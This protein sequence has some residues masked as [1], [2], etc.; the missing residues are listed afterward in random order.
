VYALGGP[1]PLPGQ[2]PTGAQELTYTELNNPATGDLLVGCK[3][4]PI[5]YVYPRFGSTENTPF[6]PERIV[7]V[8][9]LA[10]QLEVAELGHGLFLA[11]V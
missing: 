6:F 10:A 7:P 9:H 3:G 1:S 11:G 4:R 2:V 5:Q 8:E